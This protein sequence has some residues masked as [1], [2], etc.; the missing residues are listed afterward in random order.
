MLYLFAPLQAHVVPLWR[1]C[2]MLFHCGP[3]TPC[4]VTA[5]PASHAMLLQ[6]PHPVTK[7]RVTSKIFFLVPF[8]FFSGLAQH[9]LPVELFAF[10]GARKRMFSF[11]YGTL[12]SML[13]IV[14]CCHWLRY[15]ALS[16]PACIK[17]TV[18]CCMF[19]TRRSSSA[20]GQICSWSDLLSDQIHPPTHPPTYPPRCS[21]W[22]N[23]LNFDDFL[24]SVLGFSCII[25]H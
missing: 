3:C 8:C 6:P 17:G 24:Y 20:V 11:T 21:L 10:V 14:P 5:A 7:N 13:I 23:I 2:P 12:H 25:R 18:T 4:Y 16:S 15:S 9:L 22:K 1:L 19:N